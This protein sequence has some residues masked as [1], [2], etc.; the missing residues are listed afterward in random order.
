MMNHTFIAPRYNDVAVGSVYQIGRSDQEIE[1]YDTEDILRRAEVGFPSVRQ[2][3]VRK[4]DVGIRP[5]RLGGPRIEL[6]KKSV[7]IIHNYGHGS[8]GIAQHYSCSL[9]VCKLAEEVLTINSKL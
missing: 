6:E 1:P 7:P 8:R 2:A 4:I 5:A 3:R 9:K